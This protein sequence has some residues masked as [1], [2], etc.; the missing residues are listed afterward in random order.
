[1]VIPITYP[2]FK[3]LHFRVLYFFLGLKVS[4]EHNHSNSYTPLSPL[5]F[6]CQLGLMGKAPALQSC[7]FLLIK[8]FPLKPHHT[9]SSQTEITSAGF[10]ASQML[11]VPIWYDLICYILG[12][13]NAQKF[14]HRN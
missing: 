1:M 4:T 11:S 2:L 3:L 9:D 13:G 8:A 6:H 10:L 5:S 14:F 12:V 7:P